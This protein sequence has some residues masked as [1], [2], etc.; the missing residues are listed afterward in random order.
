MQEFEFERHKGEG[1]LAVCICVGGWLEDAEDY[2]RA[3]GICACVGARGE[4]VLT[5]F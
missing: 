4:S 1:S 2:K 3:F 5:Y